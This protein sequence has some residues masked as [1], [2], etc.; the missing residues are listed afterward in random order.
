MVELAA[1][2]VPNRLIGVAHE[3][4]CPASDR[5]VHEVALEEVRGQWTGQQGCFGTSFAEHLQG[6][7]RWAR[8][9]LVR[10]S[11][12]HQRARSGE[13]DRARCGVVRLALLDSE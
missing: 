3:D 7:H 13:A 1:G 5:C 4:R 9:P 12:F 11:E 2:D 8:E 10:T 6:D